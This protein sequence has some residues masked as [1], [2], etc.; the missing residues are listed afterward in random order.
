MVLLAERVFRLRQD[1]H[2]IVLVKPAQGRDDRQAA[3]K[4]RNNAELQQIVRLHELEELS[5]VVVALAL[6]RR[7]EAH[8][9]GIGALLNDLVKPVERAAA[10]EENVGRVDL[11]ELLL[12]VLASALRGT[13]ATVPSTIFKSACWTPSPET[14]RVME[15]FSDLRAIL[16]IS[17]I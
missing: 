14:S 9:R 11:N 10:D 2:Q 8:G 4:L 3:H 17:S 13:F 1:A 12:R 16:S 6:D 15:V 5:D 7:V